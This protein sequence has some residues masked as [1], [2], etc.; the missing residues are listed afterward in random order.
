MG[1]LIDVTCILC[2]ERNPNFKDECGRTALDYAAAFDRVD[3]I[4]RLL[5]LRANINEFRIDNSLKTSFI[6]ALLRLNLRSAKFLF[7]HQKNYIKILILVMPLV[8]SLF[9]SFFLI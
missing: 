6:I 3:L 1:G 4:K 9:L 7:S 5:E 2:D 8:L